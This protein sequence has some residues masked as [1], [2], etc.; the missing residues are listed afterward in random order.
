V[1]ETAEVFE[2][3]VKSG[4]KRDATKS[5]Q[6]GSLY[7]FHLMLLVPILALTGCTHFLVVDSTPTGA[8]VYLDGGY[9]GMTPLRETYDI[10]FDG[11]DSMRTVDVELD[12][13][14][15]E[16]IRI[17]EQVLDGKQLQ[18]DLVSIAPGIE[19]QYAGAVSHVG[20]DPGQ[21]SASGNYSQIEQRWALAIGISEYQHAG[22][23]GLNNLIYAD[24]DAE[25][26]TK[27]LQAYGW[28]RD[29]VKLL[30]NEQATQRNIMVALE[31]WLTKAG[32][33]DQITL[34]W[35][36]HGFPDPEDPEKV[37]FACHDTDM[38]IP[39]TGYRMDKVRTALEE[40]GV[41]NVILLADTCHAGKL[42]TRGDRGISIVPTIDKMKR[43]KRIPK[44]WVFMVG[45]DTDRQAIEHSSWSNGAFTHC[46]LK[47]LSGEADGY[48]S[49]GAQD[50]LVTMGELKEYMSVSMPDETQKV[51]GVAKRPLITT[52][53]GDPNIWNISLQQ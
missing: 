24:N 5:H 11:A 1:R 2:V 33:N 8:K 12:G 37:Y 44:G 28:R 41:K 13:Y 51:L 21:G 46:L 39:A 6:H 17:T 32:P 45:A 10:V 19:G 31:S 38:S 40:R 27:T 43:Q 52:S 47:G 4:E 30:T 42:I 22:R 49:A 29:H 9:M 23:N 15:R 50:G 35:A 26:F 36:G 14:Q 18:V 25:A 7:Q 53:S 20:N 3:D 34:F 16:T 48:Q